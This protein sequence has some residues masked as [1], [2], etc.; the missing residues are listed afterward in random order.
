MDRDVNAAVVI[1]KKGLG[2]GPDQALGLDRS[3]VT[4]A[5]WEASARVLGS[6][7]YILVSTPTMKQEA[8]SF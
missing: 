2:L 3:E 4:P 5:E 8:H 6:N 7:P 1:L